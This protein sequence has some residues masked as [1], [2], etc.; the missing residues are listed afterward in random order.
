MDS[1]NQLFSGWGAKS[2][3]AADFFAGSFTLFGQ[4]INNLFAILCGVVL[5][6][7][8]L[9]IVLIAC[10]AHRKK[11]RR[12]AQSK[13]PTVA[14]TARPTTQD[15][16]TLEII[17]A[18]DIDDSLPQETLPD[19]ADDTLV[20]E[21]PAAGNVQTPDEQEDMPTDTTDT[22]ATDTVT[23]DELQ[24]D[25]IADVE[26]IDI[27]APA[28]N[29]D[30]P[31]EAT[32]TTPDDIDAVPELIDV[33]N[34][35]PDEAVLTDTAVVD[36]PVVAEEPVAVEEPAV[37]DEP[38]V[39]E[40]AVA[41]EQAATE[42]A[43][44]EKPAVVEE[45]AVAEEPAMAVEE[46]AVAE[47]PAV[48]EK[49]AVAEEPAAAVE[50]PVAANEPAAPDAAADTTETT[51]PKAA[52][53]KTSKPRTTAKK[54]APAKKPVATKEEPMN[55]T[56]K[57]T[58]KVIGSYEITLC[59]DGYRFMLYANNKQLLYE[60]TGFTTVDGA[61]KGIETFRKTVAEAAPFVTKDKYDRYRYIFNKR[62]QG[63]NYSTKAQAAKCAESVKR[64]A[65][66]AKVVVID[67]TPEELA[68]YNQRRAELRTRAD[69]DWD[70]IAKE[71][72]AAKK[73]GKLLVADEVIDGEI[74]GY[75][76][77]MVANNGQI[78]YTSA[79][80]A[81]AKSALSGIDAFKRAIYIGNLY[82][83]VDK[84][85]HY[86]YIL[87]GEG[88]STY[89]GESY[90]TKAQA[91][92]SAQSIRKFAACATIVPYEKKDDAE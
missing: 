91:E 4:A 50:E 64:F 36:E 62:Y 14:T 56:A 87:R 23:A 42:P 74:V 27:Q 30:V 76:Y 77:Y 75:R 86:R 41:E 71:E 90:T 25:T 10:I 43:T 72:A 5:L 29:D 45:P 7:L 85:G 12:A 39:E 84:F 13:A 11:V 55:D 59:I 61:L 52:T 19:N 1:I 22:D 20:V 49:T 53:T 78:L 70:A 15:N 57:E 24:E 67:P 80:Y 2:P 51:A 92:S 3:F 47:E 88:N 69:V 89:M 83:D 32:D 17:E 68:T 33:T 66:D 21:S 31:Q 73:M 8:I 35:E 18:D 48:V 9:V 65:P 81:S 58:K 46:P 28:A 37:V 38:V 40:P 6:L 16:D 82:I 44:E 63:E 60:S 34:E 26:D 79:I 54:S